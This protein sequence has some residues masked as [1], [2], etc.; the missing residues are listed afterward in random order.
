MDEETPKMAN[1]NGTKAAVGGSLGIA[2]AAI[3]ALGQSGLTGV[4][5]D[6][7]EG[8]G[9]L[10]EDIEHVED[11]AIGRSTAL[12]ARLH[13]AI[14]G[15]DAR[16][17]GRKTAMDEKLAAQENVAEVATLG[18]KF[19]EV[20]EQFKGRDLLT[21]ERLD[22]LE[23]R[24][25]EIEGWM[26]DALQGNATQDQQIATIER[27]VFGAGIDELRALLKHIGSD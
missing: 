20:E 7:V 17:E 8:D 11:R 19:K 26:R 6:V 16:S 22:K 9:R 27:Q 23:H 24:L 14:D 3:F 18:E 4:K 15:V 5:G 25:D 21:A 12:E 13:N 1:G 2:L 10:K